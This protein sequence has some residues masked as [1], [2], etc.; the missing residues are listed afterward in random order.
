[1]HSNTRPPCGQWN[2]FISRREDTLK[3][4]N[5]K[6][7]LG[8]AR[9]QN[10]EVPKNRI[11]TK[12]FKVRTSFCLAPCDMS[13]DQKSF[14]KLVRM[15][16]LILGG[17]FGWIFSASPTPDPS[18]PH[19]M[20]HATSKKNRSC[21][22]IFGELRCRKW[23]ATFAFLQCRRRFYQKLRCN[24]RT[25]ALQHWKVARK[26]RFPAAFLRISSSHVGSCWFSQRYCETNARRL[27]IQMFGVL[28]YKWEEYWSISLSRAQWHQK[29]CNRNWRRIAMQIEGVLQYFFE[30]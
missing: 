4:D 21:A 17:F 22:A 15:N 7:T 23:T 10:P 20:Q 25:T 28:R 18:K 26:W 1:M 13:Q 14:R 6:V 12:S 16:F 9:I 2:W 24:K 19:P 27:A 3:N 11:Y 30:K 5:T 29:H 8:L